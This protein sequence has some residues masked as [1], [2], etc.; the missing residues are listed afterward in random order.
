MIKQK[1]R[2][3]AGLLVLGSFGLLCGCATY[4]SHSTP[5]AIEDE[6]SSAKE[7]KAKRLDEQ[8]S[9]NEQNGQSTESLLRQEESTHGEGN[10]KDEEIR[11][12]K[13][14]LYLVTGLNVAAGA[15]AFAAHIEPWWSGEKADFRVDYD[16]YDG[17]HLEMDKLG[18]F[19]LNIQVTRLS[20]ASWEWAG[21]SRKPALWLGALTSTAI[22]TAVELMDGNYNK[23]GFSVPDY[24][25]NLLGAAYPIAQ[26]Y[27]K[28]LRHFNF[29]FSYWPSE[30]YR[31]DRDL[32]KHRDGFMGYE[33]TDNWM[34]DYDGM[35]FWLSADVDWMLPE[36]L[37]PY[38][39]DWLNIAFGYGAYN[40]SQW[41]QDI[42][43]RR[44]F[45][46]L[47]YNLECLP[48][49]SAFMK[50]LK[51]VLNIIHFP[52]PTIRMTPDGDV[53]FYLLYFA[54]EAN[55]RLF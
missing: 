51:S 30:F 31:N 15:G 20:A 3:T 37:K 7:A 36:V 33:P 26:E 8:K 24:V 44:W 29:K 21:I 19:F 50:G 47:D 18:H 23:W 32:N 2:N 38:W 1:L 48:G 35:A 9:T 40:L 25:A 6:R 16:W 41:N 13:K 17:Y 28:P 42:K 11:I 45:I 4:P 43:E 52:A 53:S 39:P 14:R 34:E 27:F 12:S 22:Y 55:L 10:L 49:D 46:A 54:P 5:A